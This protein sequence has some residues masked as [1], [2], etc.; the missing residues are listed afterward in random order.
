MPKIAAP[1]DI[2]AK[3]KLSYDFR[4]TG[5]V[6]KFEGFL[7]F[8]EEDKKARAA[9]KAKASKEVDF[10]VQQS[11]DGKTTVSVEPFQF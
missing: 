11:A 8:E 1:P 4:V 5:S 3:A 7:K 9:A 6:L 2:V 10:T